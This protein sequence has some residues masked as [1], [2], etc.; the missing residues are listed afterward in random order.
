MKNLNIKT[1]AA[2]E[3]LNESLLD[4]TEDN[5]DELLNELKN[6]VKI[7]EDIKSVS[8]EINH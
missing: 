4:I 5:L 3:H 7:A 8:S 6:L 1:Q 2:I